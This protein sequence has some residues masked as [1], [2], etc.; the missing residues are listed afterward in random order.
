MY[1]L[2]VF[3][4]I[5]VRID[6]FVDFISVNVMKDIKMTVSC[7]LAKLV[8]LCKPHKQDSLARMQNQTFKC[9]CMQ[10]CDL[11]SSFKYPINILKTQNRRITTK[12]T[13]HLS[14][15]RCTSDY[16]APPVVK[17]STLLLTQVESKWKHT[18]ATSRI[19][20]TLLLHGN[21]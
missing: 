8:D 18:W 11:I 5:F 12:T 1:Y 10:I 3:C 14:K 20:G 2:V 4:S 16:P 7:I 13:Q 17:S 19:T 21:E 6:E 15:S 9:I